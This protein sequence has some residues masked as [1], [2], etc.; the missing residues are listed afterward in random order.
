MSA[1]RRQKRG[2]LR[3][4]DY[5][6]VIL[7]AGFAAL[8]VNSGSRM[9]FGLLLKPMTEDL[10]WSRS[11]LSL[12][13]TTFFCVSALTMPLLGR[14]VDRYSLRAVMGVTALTGAVGIGLMAFAASRWQVFALYGLVYAA[15]SAGS[16]V[17]MV[18]VLVSR[19]FT[20]RRGLANSAAISGNAVGQLVIITLLASFLESLRWRG[21][22]LAL[23]A[24][25]LA[26]APL[27]LALVRSRP[28]E[29][30]GGAEQAARVAPA[31]A[32]TAPEAGGLLRS[33]QM[34]L[35]V[36]VYAICGFQDFFVATHVVAFADDKGVPRALAGNLLAVMGLLGMFGVLVSGAMADRHGA[37]LPTLLS[38]IARVG[39][40]AIALLFQTTLGVAAFA[41][42]YGFT[43]LITAPLVIVFVGNVFGSSRMGAISGVIN[44]THQI[45]GGLG[46]YA[47]ALIFDLWGGYDGAFALMLALSVAGA[48]ATLGVRERLR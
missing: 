43:F 25:N 29:A 46:A 1:A 3:R 18:G 38:F 32:Q 6:W 2:L 14:L 16:S 37:A 24:A 48:A 35:L 8:F 15:G 13:A 39:I 9:A 11:S 36:V 47:G 33:R 4:I 42:L 5:G 27:M 21:A 19:W 34:W 20:H 10:G 7:C 45:W 17:S 44:M 22:Y 12:A 30:R 41:V 40:F 23:G 31:E 28:P 26:L